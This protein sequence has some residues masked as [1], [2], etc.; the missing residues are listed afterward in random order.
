[1]I[2]AESV[3]LAGSDQRGV[4]Y[5]LITLEQLLDHP[6]GLPQVEIV[7]WPVIP[8]RYHHD[9]ISRKQISTVEDFKR[10]LGRLVR[11]KFTHY[12]L[13]IEDVLHLSS[14]PEIGEGRGKLMPADIRELVEEAESLGIEIFP[15]FSLLSHHENLLLLPR[16]AHLAADVPQLASSLDPSLPA[17]RDFLGE[18][19][20]EVCS[21]F[22]STYF[23]MG[24]DETQ[25][26][27]REHFLAHAN[28]CAEQ[29]EGQGKR[30]L[31]WID[32][33]YNP[34][35]GFGFDALD[36]L[37]PS[38]LPV[39]WCY[40]PQR[41]IDSHRQFFV[42]SSARRE[43]W[44]LAAYNNTARFIPD[45]K[46]CL[47]AIKLWTETLEAHQGLSLGGSQWGD[48][49]YENHR[50]LAW[51]QFATLAEFAWK[52]SDA[53]MS[54]LAQ[55]FQRNFY[56]AKLPTVATLIDPERSPF[57]ISGDRIWKA[58]RAPHAAL[59]RLLAREPDL[60]ADAEADLETIEKLLGGLQADRRLARR[61]ADHLIHWES[62]LLR[63]RSVLQRILLAR[64]HPI[65]PIPSD[66]A[67][68]ETDRKSLFQGRHAAPGGGGAM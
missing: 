3:T 49:G 20:P 38:V 55:R 33:F 34:H 45:V 51:N 62:A 27:S 29:L 5:A 11:Y 16:H 41:L 47:H 57:R 60:A 54:T 42:E 14:H 53:D 43:T 26:I 23:H 68:P 64:N 17:V 15:T 8:I 32:R 37:H 12:T 56:G 13:Y 22:P 46:D 44:A 25:G 9:D 66:E 19:I 65:A 50:A 18:I 10:I 21:L 24:F 59:V 35:H 40:Q 39:V 36:Q 1:M 61:E 58:H 7:D 52:G 28:W 4:L 67:A 48:H 6:G 30:P 31:I 63:T 2:D